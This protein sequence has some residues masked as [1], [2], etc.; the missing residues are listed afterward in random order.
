VPTRPFLKWAGGKRQLLPALRRYYPRDFGAYFEPFLGSGAVFFDLHAAGLLDGRPSML[1]DTNRDVIGTYLA[2]RDRLDRVI[3]HLKKLAAGHAAGG[4]AH[5]YDVRDER[6]NPWRERLFKPGERTPAMPARYPSELAAM[7]I[8]LNRTGYN[9]LFRLNRRGG[10]NVPAGRYTNPRICDVDTLRA[11][12]TA[13]TRPGVTVA[14]ASFDHVFDVAR[15]GDFLYFDPPYA[16]LSP[17]ARF[18]A[19]TADGFDNAAQER[20]QRLMVTLAHRGCRLLLSNSNAPVIRA[21][22]KDHP[23]VT[24]AGLRIVQVPARRAINSHAGRRGPIAESLIMNLPASRASRKRQLGVD[25][26]IANGGRLRQFAG[27]HR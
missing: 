20:L 12:H 14:H 2:V 11:V 6:F 3:V 24:A 21:L 27:G 13:L 10:F 19:Y 18:T 9:G 7:F 8:Y 5:Y 16:P 15:A 1:T 25:S 26:T 22:Y 17:T 23:E 4:A